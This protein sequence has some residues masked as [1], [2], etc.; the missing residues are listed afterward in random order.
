ML[1]FCGACI[2][3]AFHHKV[4]TAGTL[5][6]NEQEIPTGIMDVKGSPMVIPSFL[7]DKE[8]TTP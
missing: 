5:R 7:F 8:M 2:I 4:T 6:R 1:Y 3:H